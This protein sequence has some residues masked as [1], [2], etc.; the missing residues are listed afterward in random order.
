MTYTQKLFEQ[1]AY[2]IDAIA[3]EPVCHDPAIRKRLLTA[4][5]NGL[6]EAAIGHVR[7]E[8]LRI[9]NPREFSEL[10]W[11]SIDGE[12]FDSMVDELVKAKNES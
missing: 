9:L 4:C 2:S 7:Y 11:R 3:S 12:N 6:R 10:S 1:Y 5:A 8:A